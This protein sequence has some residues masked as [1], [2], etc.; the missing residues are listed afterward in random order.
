MLDIK[1][2]RENVEKVKKGAKDK[3]FNIKLIDEL[4]ELDK[5]RT[6]LL[7]AVEEMRSEQNKAAK[8]IAK[9]KGAEKD[10]AVKEM[11]KKNE[12]MKRQGNEEKLKVIEEK[13]NR[14]MLLMPF[15][16]LDKVPLGKDDKDNVEIRTW[17]NIPKFN[18]EPKDHVRLGEDLDILD[19]PRGVKISG[20]RFYFLKNEGALLE[21]AILKYTLDKLVAKGFVPFIPPV[22]V[23]YGA[24]MGTGYFPGG[25]EQAYAVGVKREGEQ[26]EGDGLWLVG[27]SEVSV[28]SY[29]QDEILE[30]D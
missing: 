3:G 9:L 16:A 7:I 24:M 1:F 12:E 25:E 8:D 30:E 18:F 10:K 14:L 23:Q 6:A 20:S 2:I 26:M 5:E 27:T 21:M 4:L 17:G 28:T 29:H 19:I 11:R 13:Y 22:L 15:P